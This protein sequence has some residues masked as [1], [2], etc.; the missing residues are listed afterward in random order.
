MNALNLWALAGFSIPDTVT[1]LFLN[2]VT[3]GW[4]MFGVLVVFTLYFLRN[5][6]DA[7][8]DLLVLFSAFILSFGFFMLPTRIHERYLFPALSLLILMFPF[9]KKVRPIY[10][11]LSFTYLAN[12]AYAL[13]FL[14][15]G[16][17]IQLGDPVV[18][19]IA[20]I[21]LLTFLYA[22]ALMF[23]SNTAIKGEV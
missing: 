2:L 1:F 13:D 6:A 5:R 14:N 3:V 7:S 18:Q 22:L 15:S 11:A 16:R 23:K 8:N 10:G 9:I 19:I 21:N 20:L 4:T 12:Q 17:Y